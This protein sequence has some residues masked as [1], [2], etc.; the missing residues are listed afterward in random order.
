MADEPRADPLAR[1]ILVI[2]MLGRGL[3]QARVSKERKRRI[4]QLQH[5]SYNK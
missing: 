1:G 3:L 5:K 4:R 2:E